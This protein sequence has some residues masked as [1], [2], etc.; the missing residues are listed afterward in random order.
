[1]DGIKLYRKSMARAWMEEQGLAVAD[2]KYILDVLPD[3]YMT[4][5]DP[6]RLKNRHMDLF[7]HP[8]GKRHI[9]ARAFYVH[10]KHLK[11][12]GTNYGSGCVNC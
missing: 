4:A 6:S 11:L 5:Q 1:V 7:G 3:H 12:Y 8:S 9:S 2:E 10:F